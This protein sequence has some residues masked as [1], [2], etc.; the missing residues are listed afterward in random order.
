MTAT[1]RKQTM[2]VDDR[3]LNEKI[4]IVVDDIKHW[5]G[6]CVLFTVMINLWTDNTDLVECR[7]GVKKENGELTVYSSLYMNEKLRR[8]IEYYDENDNHV[9]TVKIDTWDDNWTLDS[10]WKLKED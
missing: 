4:K 1:L 6:K 10:V 9:E 2:I 5:K 8:R 7:H 3:N